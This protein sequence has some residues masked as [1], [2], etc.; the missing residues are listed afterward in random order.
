MK[1]ASEFSTIVGFFSVSTFTHY[2]FS[3]YSM[4][5]TKPDTVGFPIAVNDERV[6]YAEWM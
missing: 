3:S 1:F 6:K 4:L 2:K 5:F